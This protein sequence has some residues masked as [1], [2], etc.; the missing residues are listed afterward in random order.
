MITDNKDF[1]VA[2]EDIADTLGANLTVSSKGDIT[3]NYSSYPHTENTSEVRVKPRRVYHFED[4][5]TLAVIVDLRGQLAA[6]LMFSYCEAKI[7]TLYL[8]NKS[9]IETYKNP[10]KTVL[11]LYD[12]IE[13]GITS[14]L[15][16]DDEKGWV[17]TLA[18][19]ANN[20]TAVTTSSH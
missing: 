13:A 11:E 4:A 3:I 17:N 19:R 8:L 2:V 10:A 14:M 20:G 12:R 1:M 9:C 5:N 18:M 16:F 6:M 7:R 15:E